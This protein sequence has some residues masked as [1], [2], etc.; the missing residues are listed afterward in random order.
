MIF[1]YL[2]LSSLL[3]NQG[4]FYIENGLNNKHNLN[5]AQKYFNSAV[6]SYTKEE[7]EIGLANAHYY[8]GYSNELRSEFPE[9]IRS[10]NKSLKYCIDNKLYEREYN[11]NERLSLIFS[12][13]NIYDKSLYYL[14]KNKYLIDNH[15]NSGEKRNIYFYQLS[16]YYFSIKNNSKSLL[17]LNKINTNNQIDF[18]NK[19][20]NL[21]ALN[22]AKLGNTKKAEEYYL[23]LINSYP[24]YKIGL[25]NISKFYFS[26]QNSEKANIYFKKLLSLEPLENRNDENV[27]RLLVSDLYIKNYDYKSALII[28]DELIPYFSENKIYNRLLEALSLKRLV[29]LNLEKTSNIVQLDSL[30][31]EIRDNQLK[32]QIE[33]NSQVIY[34][35]N[36][37]ELENKEKE[38]ELFQSRVIIAASI[39]VIIILS[40]ISFLIYRN[41]VIKISFANS[42][43]DKDLKIY[44]THNLVLYELNKGINNFTKYMHLNYEFENNLE[45]YEN[46]EEIVKANVQLVKVV[47]DEPLETPLELNLKSKEN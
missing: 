2:I 17:Y 5:V 3:A 10:F 13:L 15:L 14:T 42:N 25:V 38:K 4:D 12:S 9:A 7:N 6:I 11:C 8:L 22:Y 23:K 29:F 1:L 19:Y 47:K 41:R 20:L 24:N 44:Q 36:E 27:N 18:E 39:G 37:I 34:A 35:L 16:N 33:A 21:Y 46:F 40:I 31:T 43:I 32:S 26:Q 28:L 45:L 30:I